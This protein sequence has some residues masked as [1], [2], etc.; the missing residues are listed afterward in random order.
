MITTFFIVPLVSGLALFFHLGGD[1]WH[2]IHEW[3][4]I[5]LI[6]PFAL[7]LWKN[8]RPMMN[9]FKRTPMM[10]ATIVAILASIPFFAV[11]TEEVGGPP[12]FAFAAQLFDNNVANLA[13]ALGV[14]AEAV[15]ARLEGFGFDM[16]DPERTLNEIADTSGKNAF[17]LSAAL[18]L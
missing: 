5:V 12:Q 10:I 17:A 16:S 7:H 4:S 15:I 3:L 6:L 18:T 2:G 9:Y 11:D 14:P 13:P 1:A 8:W